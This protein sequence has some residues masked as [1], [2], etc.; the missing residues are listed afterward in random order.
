[1]IRRG[2]MWLLALATLA[3]GGTGV[4]L[5]IMKEW[6]EPADPFSVVNH[7][8]QPG[9]LKAHLVA[10]PFLIFAVGLIFST[11]AANRFRSGGAG[12]RRSGVG[13]LALFIPLVLSGVAVQ[14]L[15]D[16]SWRRGAVWVHLL[17]GAAY[18]GSFIVHRVV[19]WGLNSPRH[20]PTVRL[21]SR[22]VRG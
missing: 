13:L 5:Y 16:E 21:A 17:V 15:V 2:E 18:L 6:M 4:V 22:R 10:V 8:W 20:R 12:G 9:M 3:A 19:A 7:P 14:I 11:H 1:V